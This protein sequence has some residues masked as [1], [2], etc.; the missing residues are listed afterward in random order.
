VATPKAFVALEMAIEFKKV[1]F[2]TARANA[3]ILAAPENT[4]K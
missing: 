4:I 1:A 2:P 3:S